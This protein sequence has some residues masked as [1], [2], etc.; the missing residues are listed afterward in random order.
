MKASHLFYFLCII[1]S[2]FCSCKK[3]KNINQKYTGTYNFTIK[4]TAWFATVGT[5]DSI[6]HFTGTIS[7]SST[8]YLKIVYGPYVY[9]PTT[10]QPQINISGTITPSVNENGTLSSPPSFIAQDRFWGKFDNNGNV[11]FSFGPQ[12]LGGGWSNEVHGT[13]TM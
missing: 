7:D 3:D 6:V 10:P 4:A 12:G 13:K 8:T 1:I 9:H 5:K 2:L 11:D